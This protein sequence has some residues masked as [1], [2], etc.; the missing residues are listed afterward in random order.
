MA[1]KQYYAALNSVNANDELELLAQ[2]TSGIVGIHARLTLA[3]RQLTEGAAQ[4]QM[5]KTEAIVL[6]DKAVASFQQVQRT[7]SDPALL[8]KAGFGLGQ[9]WE[10]LAAARVGGE[11][12]A[13]SEEE[14]QRVVELWGESFEG[15]RAQRRLTSLRQP[16]TR[17]FIEL[18]AARVVE[19]PALDDTGDWDD[20]R[21]SFSL[22]DP[23]MSPGGP[24]DLAPF[25]EGF[26]ALE[27]DPA[28]EQD[29]TD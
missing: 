12:L 9:C 4:V 27:Q 28:P 22:E 6:L 20:F 14:Y 25:G 26:G 24:I 19:T 11:D 7:A 18:M 23:F 8:R 16:A 3:Q 10:T 15:Q 21:R 29:P 1:W 2:T 13:K 17:M 5:D